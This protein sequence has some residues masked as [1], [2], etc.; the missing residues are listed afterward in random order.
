[1]ECYHEPVVG[2]T[3]N[4]I[5]RRCG[6]PIQYINGPYVQKWYLK[7]MKFTIKERSLILWYDFIFWTEDLFAKASGFFNK[8]RCNIDDKH[9]YLIRKLK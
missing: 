4:F 8:L 6:K 2:Q 9:W 5:C 1:M 7:E 3:E